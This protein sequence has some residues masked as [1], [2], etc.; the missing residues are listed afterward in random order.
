MYR[1]RFGFQ[2]F[3][4]IESNR[5]VAPLALDQHKL[6]FSQYD[7]IHF[8]IGLPPAADL[9]GREGKPLFQVDLF[10]D[11]SG[12]YFPVLDDDNSSYRERRDGKVEIVTFHDKGSTGLLAGNEKRRVSTGEAPP[13]PGEMGAPP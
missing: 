1:L 7:Y 11:L 3:Q 6:C 12:R 9:F 4:D 5:A 13:L 2:I 10:E 8:L